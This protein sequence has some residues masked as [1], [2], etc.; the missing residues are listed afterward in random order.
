MYDQ[1]SMASSI[2][3]FNYETNPD[4][5]ITAKTDSFEI[6]PRSQ[7]LSAPS[8]FCMAIFFFFSTLY[9]LC[10]WVDLKTPLKKWLKCLNDYFFDSASTHLV[11]KVNVLCITYVSSV[12]YTR[13]Q[14][15]KEQ[16]T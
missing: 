11:K 8:S 5:I 12:T 6:S 4:L 14:D 10:Y 9:L 15:T 2:D 7:E 13:I 3:Y 1:K 16:A